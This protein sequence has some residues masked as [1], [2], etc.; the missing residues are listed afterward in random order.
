M[1]VYLNSQ[2]NAGY[3]DSKDYEV[4][5]Y[6]SLCCEGQTDSNIAFLI[7]I[8]RAMNNALAGAGKMFFEIEMQASLEYA[9]LAL[10]L[11]S[12][13]KFRLRLE[14]KSIDRV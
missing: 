14:T 8:S 10:G 1:L 6:A 4:A 11:D 3:A 5:G 12:G 9:R 13:C 7:Y 2:N